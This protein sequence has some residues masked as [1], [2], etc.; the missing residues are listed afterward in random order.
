MTIQKLAFQFSFL[1]H[2]NIAALAIPTKRAREALI[3]TQ[4]PQCN[5]F[6]RIRPGQFLKEVNINEIE[7]DRM[8]LAITT[9]VFILFPASECHL[10]LMWLITLGVS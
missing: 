2:L 6:D 10:P 1:Q 9:Y 7:F 8:I 5:W 3:T 4:Q